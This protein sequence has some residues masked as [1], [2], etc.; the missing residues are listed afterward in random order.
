MSGTPSPRPIS[1]EEQHERDIEALKSQLQ[2]IVEDHKATLQ[3]QLE[4]HRATLERQTEHYKST[5][6]TWRTE[7]YKSKL[8]RWNNAQRE[9]VSGQIALASVAIR[10]IT[11][12]NGGGA[13]FL[14]AFIG[15]VWKADDPRARQLIDA[16]AWPIGCYVG[17]VVAAVLCAGF[18]YLSQWA[19]NEAPLK[20]R[21][22]YGNRLR[23][24]AIADAFM[25]LVAFAVGSGLALV[26]FT[27][28]G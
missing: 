5:R 25:A 8:V 16:M 19:F 7:R 3:K 11:L 17:G 24:V 10:A 1:P 6:L 26:A 23:W 13:I 14:L 12:V 28:R 15:N 4:D 20:K 22:P 27:A 18:S 2:I 21:Q 9:L